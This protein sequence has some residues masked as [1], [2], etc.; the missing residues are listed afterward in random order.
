[1]KRTYYQSD[2]NNSSFSTIKNK[3][4]NL[5]HSFLKRSSNDLAK[6][7]VYAVEKEKGNNVNTVQRSSIK[8]GSSFTI[9]KEM[10]KN[11][12]YLIYRSNKI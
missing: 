6:N 2:K 11:I 8:K 3:N 4:T 5:N 10:L 12:D 1:M 9:K 7:K